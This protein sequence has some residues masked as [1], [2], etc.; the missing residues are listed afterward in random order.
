MLDELGLLSV[1]LAVVIQLA[2]ALEEIFGN[3]E[4]FKLTVG[5]V[6]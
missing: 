4:N 5:L 1:T 3:G 2:P 6:F